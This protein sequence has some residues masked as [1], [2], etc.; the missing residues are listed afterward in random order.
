MIVALSV[1]GV[2]ED[3]V[4]LVPSLDQVSFLSLKKF[5]P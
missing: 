2:L 1:F 5:A 4:V 3:L